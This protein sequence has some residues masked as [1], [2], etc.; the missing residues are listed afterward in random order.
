MEQYG[1]PDDDEPVKIDQESER[2]LLEWLEEQEMRDLEIMEAEDMAA[3]DDYDWEPYDRDNDDGLE[4]EA[5]RRDPLTGS[6]YGDWF[7]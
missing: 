6:T 2:F 1:W 3:Y 7:D 5:M 4:Y